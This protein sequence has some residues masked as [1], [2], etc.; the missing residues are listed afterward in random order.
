MIF[1]HMIYGSIKEVK[2]YYPT[3]K[4]SP[5]KV[6]VYLFPLIVAETVSHFHSYLYNLF[7]FLNILLV[8]L[9]PVFNTGPDTGSIS[10]SK[11]L[12][13]PWWSNSNEYP[14]GMFWCKNCL[15]YHPICTLELLY[16]SVHYKTVRCKMV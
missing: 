4:L 8:L 2:S 7:F 9:L 12:E 6:H 10:K 11:L 3:Y 14:L 16:K 15:N 1:W 13:S 5:L